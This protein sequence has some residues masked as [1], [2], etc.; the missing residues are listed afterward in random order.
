MTFLPAPAE[1][2]TLPLLPDR[3]ETAR[4][5][6]IARWFAN[7]EFIPKALRGNVPAI[8]AAMLT[9][10][11]LGI[12]PM[13]ALRQI[14]MVDGKPAPAAEL[15]MALALKAGH[16]IRVTETTSER[17]TVRVR[18][19]EWP[20]DEP[21]A[22][23]TWT[24]EDAVRAGLCSIRD[25]RPYAR[26]RDNKPLP[27]EQYP[28]AMLRARAVSEACRAW[29]PDATEG[30]SYSPE[31]LGARDIRE[32][33]QPTELDD[34]L[35]GED[36]G[37]REQVREALDGAPPTDDEATSEGSDDEPILC[38]E[39]G[40]AHD[41]DAPCP[42][43]D[44]PPPPDD[45]GEPLVDDALLEQVAGVDDAVLAELIRD[46]DPVRLRIIWQALSLGDV[47]PAHRHAARRLVA[48]IRDRLDPPAEPS[49]ADP[50]EQAATWK[51]TDVIR[52]LG[53][54]DDPDLI[55]RLL[56]I[57]E[58]HEP[59]RPGTIAAIARRLAALRPAQTP[60]SAP[61]SAANAPGDADAS[62]AA[63][64]DGSDPPPPAEDAVP[65]DAG[66]ARR[67]SLA[68]RYH[69]AYREVYGVDQ[70]AAAR[71]HASRVEVL[72]T[73]EPSGFAEG[74]IDAIEA[75]VVEAER[76]RNEIVPL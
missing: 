22:E 53:E 15:Q 37:T 8:A 73:G 47:E 31:E 10:R 24:L 11:E 60:P 58:A 21:A 18:R 3:D 54:T 52:F 9:G 25:G 14:A 61:E 30:F 33:G 71:L 17:C 29:L 26:S 27:W 51:A 1:R 41:P 48:A 42:D 43:P 57:E 6:Q 55:E 36:A 63:P 32:N 28:R 65:D 2:A 23:L 5:Y 69:R 76:V 74:D 75:L 16:Y 20:D 45:A 34:P 35:A 72:R 19:A 12:L 62:D 64:G 70:A 7:T 46:A 50:L 13:R 44:S 67:R 59:R 66:T 49:A 56:T 39:C 68:A 4:L 38:G 40:T